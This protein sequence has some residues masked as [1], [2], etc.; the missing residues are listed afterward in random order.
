MLLLTL[1]HII[2]DGWSMGVLVREVAALYKAFAA[3]L[4]SPL[5]ELP[6]QYGDFAV[7]QREWM[8][9]EVL[10][11]ELD[12]WRRQLGGGDP[13]AELP[14]DRARPAARRY[15]GAS[16]SFA[17][18]GEL[19]VGVSR[20]SRGA[21]ATRFMVLLAAFKAVLHYYARRDEV[22]V[23]IN[24]ANRHRREVEGVI[25]FF[26][27][28]LALRT[29]VGGNPSFHELLRRVREV[30]LGA[31]AHQDVP[32]EKLAAAVS[33]GR[34]EAGQSPL[35]RV[36]VAYD[37]LTDMIELPGLRIRQLEIGTEIVRTDL[38][39]T[40]AEGADELWGN[41]AYD[42]DLFDAATVERMV[43]HY[44]MLLRRIVAEPEVRLNELLQAVADAD[45]AHKRKSLTGNKQANLQRLKERVRRPV[46]NSPVG[47]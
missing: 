31:Y 20:L 38:Q 32:F 23:G 15:R 22:V 42:R 12:Y 27:N 3:G 19:N 29:D 14:L 28:T 13:A 46:V 40:L 1:H 43:E 35:F 33:A 36:K 30:A 10:E 34:G 18:G 47:D 39:L 17:V 41:L 8:T 2:T 11:G 21:G 6:I 16:V 44:L 24:V 9:G 45:M 37:K 5:A 4:A 25:G 7:W 26:V